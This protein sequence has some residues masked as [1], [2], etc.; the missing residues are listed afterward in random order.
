LPARGV[1]VD[2]CTGTGALAVA[3]GAARP[4]AR[5]VAT[6]VDP[7]AVAS[8]RANGVEAYHGDLLAPV[9]A[10]LPGRVDVVIGVV[11]YVPTGALGLLPRDTLA[12]EPVLAYDGGPDGAAVL[13]RVVAGASSALR[14]GGALLLELGGHQADLLAPD[15]A[16]HGFD[17]VT[18]LRDGDGDVRG[19]EATLRRPLIPA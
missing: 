1:A 11:P 6:D 7:L 3:M 18:V 5:V 17:G 14:P 4:G 2:V 12:Y 15:L 10:A 9:P 19:V 13:R 16:R 8:A